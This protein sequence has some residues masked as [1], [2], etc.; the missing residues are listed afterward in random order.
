MRGIRIGVIVL[1]VLSLAVYGVSRYSERARQD[2]TL[3]VIASDREILE[4]TCAASEEEL[5][6]GLYASDGKDGDLT[7]QILVGGISRF[8]SDGSCAITYVVFDSSGHPA[9]LVRPAVFTDY[10][11][12]QFSLDQPLVFEKG[13][14]GD[15]ASS[16]VRASDMLDGDVTPFLSVTESN[17]SYT[18]TG[19]YTLHV[20]V[21]NSYGDLAQAALPVHVVGGEELRLQIVLKQNLVYLRAGEEFDPD[22][23][24]ESVSR[25]DGTALDTAGV[26]AQSGV[27]TAVPGIY[28]VKYTAE[29]RGDTGVTWLTVIVE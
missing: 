6:A 16:Y 10:R 1:F 2:M 27:D 26:S 23:W 19:E 25:G 24:V 3:P 7:G 29:D 28:E 11:P 4:T 18:R 21:S 17:V 20:E 5:L 15:A 8:Q 22:A 13:S 9:T 14:R 12:P